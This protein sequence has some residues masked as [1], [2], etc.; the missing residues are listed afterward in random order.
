MP[1]QHG[2][3]AMLLAPVLVGAW[4]FLTWRTLLLLVSALTGF[5]AL[6]AVGLW[7]KSGRRAR[8]RTAALVHTLVTAALVAWLVALEPRLLSWSWVFVP[9]V[10][11][12]LLA[13]ARR[14]DR[15]WWNDIVLVVLGSCLTLVSAGLT[16]RRSGVWL[17]DDPSVAV[18][19]IAPAPFAWPPLGLDVPGAWERAVV[20]LLY[21]A[22]TIVHVKALIRERRRPWVSRADVWYHAALVPAAVVWTLLGHLGA[23]GWFLVGVA[24]VLALRAWWI[25]TRRRDL[26]V[27]VIGVVEIVM[28]VLVAV[29]AIWVGA[30][31]AHG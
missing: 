17:A 7:L 3:W 30:I 31:V 26:S 11:L 16:G 23:A 27:K 1:N 20:L 2:A 12:S 4:P 10:A 9:A 15:T 6:Y 14:S 24:V 18:L 29:A 22:G 28:T 13:S 21:F 25:V 19:T 5:C 8:Y